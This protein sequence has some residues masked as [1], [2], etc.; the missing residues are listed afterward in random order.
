MAPTAQHKGLGRTLIAFAEDRARRQGY[1]RILLY[2]NL[3]MT[4]NL[5]FY[6]TLGYKEKARRTE[7]GFQR[8]WFE[9]AL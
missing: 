5:T 4:P 3:M 8:V 7:H 1:R 9:K 6:P 2:T